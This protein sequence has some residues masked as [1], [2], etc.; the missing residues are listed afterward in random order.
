MR[1]GR[2]LGDLIGSRKSFFTDAGTI[3]SRRYPA[4]AEPL[5]GLIDNEKKD[6]GTG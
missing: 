2:P 3:L 4:H 1:N 6:Y 5:Q